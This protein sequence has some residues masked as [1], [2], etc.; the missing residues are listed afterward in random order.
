MRPPLHRHGFAR[1]DFLQVGLSALGGPGL[2]GLL[3]ARA[4]AAP[5]TP[6]NKCIFIWLDGGPSH[7]E[8]F[9]PKPD[10]P[11]TIRGSFGTV[12]TSVPGIHFSEHVPR[13]A[14]VM[15]K[16]TIVRSIAH[17]QNNHGAGNHYLVT[18]K[19]T[20]APVGCG[21]FV[22]YHPSIGSVVARDRG[23]VNGIPPYFALGGVSRSGGPNFLGAT[24]APFVITE[25]PA[26]DGFRVRDVSLPKELDP[27]RVAT[28]KDLRASLDRLRRVHDA[29]Y[30]DPA[31]ALDQFYEQG[32]ELVSSESAQAAFDLSREPEATREAYGKTDFGQRLLLARRL[33]EAGVPFVHVQFGGWDHHRGIFDTLKKD[34]LPKTD[35]AV[36]A[37]IEDLH[38][39]G[40]LADTLVVMLGEFGR[41]PKINTDSGRD[42]WSFAMSVLVAGAG[43]PGGQVVGA[44]DV[45]GYYANENVYAPEDFAASLYTKLGI[46]HAQ[47]LHDTADRPVQ[48]LDK[49]KLIRELFA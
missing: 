1:R 26:S 31:V 13:L 49:A 5:G 40:S 45:K 38:R 14:K 25:N 46:D 9:D 7:Y 8:T 27:S 36:A 19:P 29:A 24:Q 28:R 2:A 47:I 30:A 20:P 23:L 32:Y 6:R 17:D 37:L 10:A 18:G 11:D 33:T 16:I 12:P 34:Y 22:S 44:T 39:R 3:A 15:D 43:V 41:T 42:H 21:A 48:L 35:Q 4:H